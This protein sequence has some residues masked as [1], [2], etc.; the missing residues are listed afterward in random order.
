M[1]RAKRA[2]SR[3]TA[4][5]AGRDA[6]TVAVAFGLGVASSIVADVIYDR[7]KHPASRRTI[8]S[9][10]D[11]AGLR[12]SA[13]LRTTKERFHD[14]PTRRKINSTVTEAD[15]EGLR[16]A[17]G[18]A[19]DLAQVKICDAALDRGP[20]SRAWKICREVILEHRGRS[21]E[22]DVPARRRASRG[23]SRKRAVPKTS[24]RRDATKHPLRVRLQAVSEKLRDIFLALDREVASG[25]LRESDAIAI[26]DDATWVAEMAARIIADARAASRNSS[27]R[28]VVAKVRKAL[29][30]T[31]P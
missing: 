10:I 2:G 7:Y 28:T 19:G 30:F 29:G 13:S 18:R 23:S 24:S 1:K 22:R 9:S 6:G 16:R 12:D 8:L 4:G 15:I 14:M 21:S 11:P 3:R 20:R 27:G 17:A 25:R 5:R 26:D 31:R